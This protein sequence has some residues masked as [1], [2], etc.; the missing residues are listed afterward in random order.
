MFDFNFGPTI[1]KQLLNTSIIKNKLTDILQIFF[2]NLLELQTCSIISYICISNTP[3]DYITPIF[4]SII[5]KIN[6][7]IFYHL[8]NPFRPLLYMLSRHLIKHYSIENYFIWKKIVV[9]T[10]IVYSII[11]LYLIPVNNQIIIIYLSQ[12]LI[13]FL[14]IEHYEQGSFH[15]I[16]EYY[17][18]R[19]K[20][21]IHSNLP[22]QNPLI[23]NY[24]PNTNTNTF[25]DPLSDPLSDKNINPLPKIVWYPTIKS[26][27]INSINDIKN[28]N[29]SF[30]IIKNK[31]CRF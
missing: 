20:T 23:T 1:F 18:L 30:I 14:V 3:I 2:A 12:S 19:P 13:S 17:Y 7:N 26:N 21:T 28:I 29:D 25:I 31:S 9:T 27:N 22:N 4:L 6:I 8:L 15:R 11:Y 5:L 16:W 24:L 10:I